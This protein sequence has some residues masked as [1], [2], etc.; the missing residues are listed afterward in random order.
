MCSNTTPNCCPDQLQTGTT[1]LI[2]GVPTRRSSQSQARSSS[3]LGKE[4]TD[5]AQM[6]PPCLMGAV[7]CDV[8]FIVSDVVSGAYYKCVRRGVQYVAVSRGSYC[9]ALGYCEDH[10]WCAIPSVFAA[11]R[12]KGVR[13]CRRTAIN[14]AADFRPPP[15]PFSYPLVFFLRE[16]LYHW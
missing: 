6:T 2:V 15:S 10:K 12:T 4:K 16:I 9:S 7:L 3:L 13:W 5:V 1:R 8:P 14:G 11:W